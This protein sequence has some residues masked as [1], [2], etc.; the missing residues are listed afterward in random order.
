MKYK[1]LLLPKEILNAPA[2]GYIA[3]DNLMLS[4]NSPN[5]KKIFFFLNQLYNIC[6]NKKI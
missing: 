3:T 4:I 2:M 5:P 6:T 1:A